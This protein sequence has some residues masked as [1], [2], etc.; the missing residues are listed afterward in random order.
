MSFLCRNPND[1]KI[2]AK[3][4]KI[5]VK[6]DEQLV[7][8]VN[9]HPLDKAVDDRLLCLYIPAHEMILSY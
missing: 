3:L 4:L 5:D 7:V 2:H 6:V 8:P 1:V 9:V